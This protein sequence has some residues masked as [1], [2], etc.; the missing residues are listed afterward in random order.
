GVAQ[1]TSRLCE[2]ETPLP[3]ENSP[4]RVFGQPDTIQ[5]TANNPTL[6]GDSLANPTGA[7]LDAQGNLYVADQNNSR[8]LEY[9]APLTDTTADLAVGQPNLANNTFNYYGVTAYS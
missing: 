9:N 1:E 6:N 5:K 7:A 8:V 4:D 2:Y 3:H